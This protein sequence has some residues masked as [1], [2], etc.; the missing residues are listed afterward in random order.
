MCGLDSMSDAIASSPSS[1]SRRPG[2]LLVPFISPGYSLGPFYFA[3]LPMLF[4][5]LFPDPKP[6][7][8]KGTAGGSRATTS[9]RPLRT[10]RESLRRDIES[11][12]ALP[13]LTKETL[14]A[15]QVRT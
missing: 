12:C 8:M 2:T 5:D 9:L 7:L 13:L 4:P 6:L 11:G 14:Y 10:H 15:T 1:G 3:L